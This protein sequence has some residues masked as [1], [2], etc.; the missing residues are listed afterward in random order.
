[1][2]LKKINTFPDAYAFT[3]GI[4]IDG[5]T[6]RC[7]IEVGLGVHKEARVRLK[8]FYAPELAGAS[9]DSGYWAKGRLQAFLDANKLYLLS[10]GMKIDKYGRTVAALSW[11]DRP[12][13]PSE[14]LGTLQMTIDQH[15]ADLA[16]ASERVGKIGATL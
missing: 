7:I 16:K 12:V 5:D 13:D 8:G 10:M 4:A 1:M 2:K 14:V 11:P 6:M 3:T 15:R 9:P